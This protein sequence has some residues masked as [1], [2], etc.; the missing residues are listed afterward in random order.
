[1]PYLSCNST[2]IPMATFPKN[3]HVWI[4]EQLAHRP[5]LITK[6]MFGCLACYLDGKLVL[7]LADKKDPWNGVL[8][9]TDHSHHPSLKKDFKGLKKHPVLGKWLYLPERSKN[10][11]EHAAR[12]AALILRGD[13]RIGVEPKP[14]RP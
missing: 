4:A 7:V 10:F 13:S 9:P 14:R 6:K 3:R 2:H 8:L 5:D 1:M 12:F 11:E